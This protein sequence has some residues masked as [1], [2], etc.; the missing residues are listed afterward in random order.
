MFPDTVTVFSVPL[1]LVLEWIKVGTHW[2]CGLCLS[3]S[4][5][6]TGACLY[7]V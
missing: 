2:S 3:L 1:W 5:W 6:Q 7:S 4:A